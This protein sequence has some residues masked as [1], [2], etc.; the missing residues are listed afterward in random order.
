MP[1]HISGSQFSSF[2]LS[3]LHKQSCLGK[4]E[5][6]FQCS[7]GNRNIRLSTTKLAND[8]FSSVRRQSTK[9]ITK[10]KKDEEIVYL[11]RIVNQ[12]IDRYCIGNNMTLSKNVRERVFV[13]VSEQ[14]G[15]LLDPRAAQSSVNHMIM[16]N[17]TFGLKMDSLFQGIS[18][19][20]K[21]QIT[22]SIVNNLADHF[23]DTHISCNVNIKTIRENIPYYIWAA[24]TIR[25]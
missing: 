15:I 17:G 4:P 9:D 20:E 3:F 2:S 19:E 12:G 18:R 16:G 5:E 24:S 10:W 11:S 21:N 25:A 14:T 22:E 7:L 6:V 23:Y 1:A 8:I 13:L